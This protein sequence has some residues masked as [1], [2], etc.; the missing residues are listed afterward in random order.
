MLSSWV[1]LG[2]PLG[3]GLLELGPQ[4]PPLLDL[5]HTPRV[6]ENSTTNFEDLQKKELDH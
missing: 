1:G 2:P 6:G 5:H 3:L 4:A